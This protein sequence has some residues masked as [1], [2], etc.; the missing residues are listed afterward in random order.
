MNQANI[1][2]MVAQL[3]HLYQLDCFVEKIFFLFEKDI[4]FILIFLKKLYN[5]L[6]W[7]CRNKQ[8]ITGNLFF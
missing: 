5:K 8:E 7:W 2:F 3:D 4:K 1:H 6:I